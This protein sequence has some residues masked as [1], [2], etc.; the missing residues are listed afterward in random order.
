M[1]LSLDASSG[2][3]DPSTCSGAGFGRPTGRSDYLI[4]NQLFE[5]KH[6]T[7]IHRTASSRLERSRRVFLD[8]RFHPSK[9][10]SE[11]MGGGFESEQ[12]VPGRGS[13]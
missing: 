5:Q 7:R 8:G 4:S 13:G 2:S 1:L 3:V 12:L 9:L 11:E 6:R 10:P